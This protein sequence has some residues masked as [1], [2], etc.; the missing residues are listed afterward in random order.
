MS[1]DHSS[2]RVLP[3]TIN[4]SVTNPSVTTGAG[5]QPAASSHTGAIAGAVVGGVAVVL[6]VIGVTLFVRRRRRLSRR[7][8]AGSKFST[9]FMEG[10]PSATVTPFNLS[11]LDTTQQGSNSWIEQQQLLPEDPD[12]GMASD[13]RSLSS[14]ST[15]SLA[16]PRS[17]PV[18]PVPPGLSSK[19]LAR[20]R[21]EAQQTHTQHSSDTTQSSSTPTLYT[22]LSGVTSSSDNRRLH[23]EVESLRREMQQLRVERF[24]PPP[25]YTSGDV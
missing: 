25:S 1:D 10:G 9:S 16:L 7:K 5:E 21:T 23:S 18:A 22:A 13:P 8:S 20:L 11:P 6:L 14:T 17:R 19:E 12:G 15:P 24:E 2:Y 3:Q 4:S